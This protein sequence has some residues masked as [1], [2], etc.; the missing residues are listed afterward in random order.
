MLPFLLKTHFLYI[1]LCDFSFSSNDTKKKHCD[2]QHTCLGARYYDSFHAT[3]I[4]MNQ[5]SLELTAD[6]V[7]QRN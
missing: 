2:I 1:D 6:H 7:V 3:I 5:Y 4:L